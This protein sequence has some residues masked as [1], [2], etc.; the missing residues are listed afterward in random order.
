MVILLTLIVGV[1]VSRREH[2]RHRSPAGI[3]RPW[4]EMCMVWMQD[5]VVS[6]LDRIHILPDLAYDDLWDIPQILVMPG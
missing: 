2:K 5:F 4:S 6:H 1:Q 3:R